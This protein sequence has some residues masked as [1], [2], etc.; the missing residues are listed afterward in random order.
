MQPNDSSAAASATTFFWHD[1]ETFGV[2]PRRDRPA[3]FAGVRTNAALEEI[4]PPVMVYCRPA[5]DF[6]PSPEACLLTGIVPQTCLERG[7]AEAEF[8]RRIEAELARPGTIGT[9]YNSLRFDDEVTR[10]LLWRSLRDPYAREWQNAC[11]RWDLLDTVRAAWALR[12]EGIRWPSH[13]DGKP[14][15]KLED[16]AAANGLL[17]EAAHDALS[18]VRA[19]IALARLVRQAQPRLFDFCLRLRQKNAVLAEIGVGRPFVHISGRYPTER[20]CLAVVWPLAPHPT[21]RNELV[22]WDLAHDPAELLTLDAAAIRARLFVSRDALPEGV[23]RLPIK[24]IHLNRS[25][26]VISS[27]KT[28]AGVPAERWGVDLATCLRHAE[29]A[30]RESAKLA[31]IWPEVYTRPA[32]AAPVDVDE[33]LYGGLVGPNDRRLLERLRGL[34]A[35]RLA[36]LCHDRAPAFDDERLA[37]LLFRYRARNHGEQLSAPEQARW[38]AHC[39]ARLHQGQGGGLSLAAYFD[40][41]D[42]LA[43]QHEDERSAAILEALYDYAE[44]IAPEP[45]AG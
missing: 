31:G 3:Q 33:D 40:Q 21:N 25:P 39:A 22:V 18:D 38:Q 4:E 36:A 34:G 6:L 11:G 1:Y 8:A 2:N 30:A 9:G 26:V 35:T 23:S 14:S 5:P 44:A 43:Q 24:T 13:P 42:E 7:V 29:T 10:H 45:S 28:L 17:H 41:I 19:T 37:E 16:L 32:P 15:F 12:P 20:G 27:L